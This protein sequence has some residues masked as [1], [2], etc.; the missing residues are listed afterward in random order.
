M[1]TCTAVGAALT[2]KSGGSVGIGTTTPTVKLDVRGDIKLGPAG[3]FQ[4]AC[5]GEKLRIICGTVFSDGT[6]DG[7]GFTSV[8]TSTGVYSLTFDQ[9][10]S[11]DVPA[12]TVTPEWIL[13]IPLVPMVS[14]NAGPTV[15]VRIFK[16]DGTP[17][18]NTFRFT[19]IGNR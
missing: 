16:L 19:A 2:A 17:A 15:T 12:V 11:F 6:P 4:A 5:S 10:F 1:S 3:E 18:N 8:R 7:S 9:A 13:G 14:V